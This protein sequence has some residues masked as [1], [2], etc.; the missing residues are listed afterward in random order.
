MLL[1]GHGLDNVRTIEA[2]EPEEA[3][4]AMSDALQVLAREFQN[5]TIRLYRTIRVDDPQGFVDSEL[6]EPQP[7]GIFY[8]RNEEFVQGYED[9][10]RV[11]FCVEAPVGSIDWVETICLTV[12]G[13]EDE[14]RLVAGKPVALHYVE[15]SPSSSIGQTYRA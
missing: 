10:E 2:K 12:D 3:I 5:G 9:D 11:L 8:S 6:N 1:T 15:P 7:L 14:V 4:E 13:V